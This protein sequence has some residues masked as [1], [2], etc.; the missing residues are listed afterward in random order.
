MCLSGKNDASKIDGP[1]TGTSESFNITSELFCLG[2]ETIGVIVIKNWSS[3]KLGFQFI[4][5][6]NNKKLHWCR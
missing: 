1:G 4:C 5:E 6:F 2:H 3:V